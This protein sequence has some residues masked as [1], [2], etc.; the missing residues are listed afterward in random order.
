MNRMKL[1]HVFLLAGAA[2]AMTVLAAPR[3]RH[4]RFPEATTTLDTLDIVGDVVLVDPV[5]LPEVKI[6]AQTVRRRDLG[7]KP[8]PAADFPKFYPRKVAD[9]WLQRVVGS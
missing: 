9:G 1:R 2:L 4:D 7:R 6:V 3:T 5:V 8:N